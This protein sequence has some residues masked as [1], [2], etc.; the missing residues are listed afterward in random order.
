[1]C[2]NRDKPPQALMA[3]GIWATI[4]PTSYLNRMTAVFMEAQIDEHARP[5]GWQRPGFPYFE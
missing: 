5:S 1:M 2:G 3:G 4:F